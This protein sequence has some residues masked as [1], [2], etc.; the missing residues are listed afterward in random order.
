MADGSVI[1]D[2]KIDAS[3][4]EKGTDD[5]VKSLESILGYMQNIYPIIKK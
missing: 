2:T 3:G 4:V 1:I 5:I